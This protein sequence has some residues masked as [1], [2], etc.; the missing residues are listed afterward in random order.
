MKRRW[1]HLEGIPL[2]SATQA[3]KPRILIGQ[4]N[5]HLTIAR[6]VH[7]GPPNSPVATK[8]KLGWVIH[9]NNGAVQG[10]VDSD[11]VC[12]SQQQDE[13]LHNLVKQ[14]SQIDA[15]GVLKKPENLTS[16]EDARATEII[17][18]TTKRV[19]DRWET[20]L[21]WKKD[22]PEL[23]PSRDAALKRLWSVAGKDGQR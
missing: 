16:K 3:C 21:L 22:K 4:D 5:A 11:I 12:F 20:G 18:N 17:Q 13:V 23:P 7:E 15:L 9:G 6:E 14:S 8:T 1:Q 10:R 19:N 2:T